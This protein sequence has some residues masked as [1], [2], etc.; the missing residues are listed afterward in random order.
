[1]PAALQARLTT[2]AAA[3]TRTRTD[4]A[5]LTARRA[6]MM[7][8]DLGVSGRAGAKVRKPRRVGPEV[9]STSAFFL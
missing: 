4:F 8:E 2:L 9:G 7:A 1:V 3:S 6:E 5:E